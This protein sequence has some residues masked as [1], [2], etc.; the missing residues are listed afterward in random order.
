MVIKESRPKAESFEHS[1]RKLPIMSRGSKQQGYFC[2]WGTGTGYVWNFASTWISI[3]K[4]SST[5]EKYDGFQQGAIYRRRFY[6]FTRH[7]ASFISSRW[8]DLC[9]LRGYYLRES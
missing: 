2:I 4:V 9:G 7:M 5:L 3:L 8:N 1:S 6:R